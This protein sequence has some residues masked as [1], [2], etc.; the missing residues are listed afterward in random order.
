MLNGIVC[1]TTRKIMSVVVQICAQTSQVISIGCQMDMLGIV[2][3]IVF[4]M[5]QGQVITL[6]KTM[7]CAVKVILQ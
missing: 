7:K 2:Q 6:V 4:Q 3:G 1:I 5:A